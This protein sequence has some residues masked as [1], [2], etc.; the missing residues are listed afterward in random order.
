MNCE[1]KIILVSGATGQSG[2]A[3]ARHLLAGGWRV[4]AL[5]RDRTKPAS[6]ALEAAGAEVVQGDFSDERSITEALTGAYGAY[7]VQLPHDLALEVE[8]GKRFADLAKDAGVKHFVYSSVGGAERVTGIPHFESKRR[9][10]EYIETLVI[11]YTILRPVYFMENLYWKKHDIINGKFKSIGLDEDKALQMIASDDIGAFARIAFENPE[12]Y[13]GRA[14]EI[15]GDE[16]TE[17]EMAEKIAQ[18][19]RHSMEVVPDDAPQT[20]SDID[21]M[22]AWFNEKGYEANINELREIYPGLKDFETW[23][24][25]SQLVI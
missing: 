8:F 13:Q 7:S 4:R 21:I 9:I 24:I 20:F 14:L 2:G 22:N 10:E 16:L 17:A 12:I 11:P 19:L 6:Q 15:A 3:T 23:L 18:V 1:N 25:T 5:T